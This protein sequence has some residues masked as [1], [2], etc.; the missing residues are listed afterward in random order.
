MKQRKVKAKPARL[1][2]DRKAQ[3]KTKLVGHFKAGKRIGPDTR[4]EA[5]EFQD[6]EHE[7]H[8]FI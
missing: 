3:P 4:P 5:L 2:A 1:D 7:I 8:L 6:E